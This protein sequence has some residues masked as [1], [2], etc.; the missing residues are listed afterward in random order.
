MAA[1]AFTVASHCTPEQIE[2]YDELHIVDS[3]W[4]AQLDHAPPSLRHHRIYFD[5][6]GCDE[7]LADGF[8]PPA[9]RP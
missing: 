1:F 4:I 2:A 9:P 6:V 7:V 3:S 8:T 5:D